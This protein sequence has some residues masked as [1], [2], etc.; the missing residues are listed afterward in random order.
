MKKNK[1]SINSIIFLL[2]LSFSLLQAS[3]SLLDSPYIYQSVN[4]ITGEYCEADTDYVN[5]ADP[6]I[7]IRRCYSN[8]GGWSFNLPLDQHLRQPANET[9]SFSYEYDGKGQLK[10]VFKNNSTTPSINVGYPPSPVG[11]MT[12]KI[13]N[14]HFSYE[15]EPSNNRLGIPPFLIKRI[16]H[17][18]TEISRYSYRQ[19]PFLRLQLLV[20]KDDSNGYFSINEYYDKKH[21][22]VGDRQVIIED[23][24]RDFRIGRIKLQKARFGKDETPVVTARYFYHHHCTEVLDAL[25]RKTYYYYDSGHLTAIEDYLDESLYRTERLFWKKENGEGDWMLTAKAWQDA[26]GKVIKCQ[27]FTYDANGNQTSETLYGMLS[28]KNTPL[29]L[30]NSEGLVENHGVESYSK[31]CTYSETPPFLLLSEREDNGKVV[32]YSYDPK[33]FQKTGEFIGT[34]TTILKRH[35]FEYDTEKRLIAFFVDDGSSFDLHDMQGVTERQATIFTYSSEESG[36]ALPIVKEEK[37]FD[38]QSGS[39]ITAR[40]TICNYNQQ[41]Y[42][43]AKQVFNRDNSLLSSASLSYDLF[44][45]LIKEIDEK[46]TG[47]EKTFN[48]NGDLLSETLIDNGVISKQTNYTY[49]AAGRLVTIN[50]IDGNGKTDSQTFQYNYAGEKISSTDHF[51]NTSTYVYDDLSRLIATKL[52]PVPDSQDQLH[53]PV[54]CNAYDILN[55]ITESID[56][57]G[58]KIS[59]WYTAYGKPIEKVYPDGTTESFIYFPDGSLKMAKNKKGMT[60]IYE[61]DVLGRETAMKILDAACTSRF[62]LTSSYSAFHLIK[63]TKDEI[64]ST[65]YTYDQAGRITAKEQHFPEGRQRIDYLYDSAGRIDSQIESWGH[66]NNETLISKHYYNSDG[67]LL[68]TA[69]SDLQGTLLSEIPAEFNKPSTEDTIESAVLNGRGQIVKQITSTD[70]QGQT[71]TA[72]YD[73][74]D[75]M[76]T[77]IRQNSQGQV[78]KHLEMRYD[79]AGNKIKETIFDKQSSKTKV[80]Q[81]RY[82]NCNRLI[83]AI[84]SAN[85]PYAKTTH[86]LYNASGLLE[87]VIKPDGITLFHHYSAIGQ[88][89]DYYASDSSFNYRFI[90]DNQGHL[91]TVEDLIT[92]TFTNRIYNTFGQIVY[93]ELGNGLKFSNTYDAIGRRTRLILPDNSSIACHFDPL[94]MRTIERFSGSG[95]LKYTH[96]Y[97]QYN[98]NGQVL[99]AAMIGAAGPLSLDYNGGRCIS[100]TASQW[101]EEIPDDGQDL[102]GNI[103]ALEGNDNHGTWRSSFSYNDCHEL[104]KEN[105]HINQ[106]YTYDSNGNRLARNH[107]AYD[108]N[109]FDQLLSQ[110]E[111]NNGDDAIVTYAYDSHGNLNE[112]RS[113]QN[114]TTYRYDALD[115]LISIE[116]EKTLFVQY[117]YDAFYRRLTKA[118]SVWNENSSSWTLRNSLRYLYDGDKEIG[119]VDSQG[120]ILELRVL[121]VSLMGENLHTEIGAAIAH[122]IH[123]HPFAPVHDHRGNVCCLIDSETGCAVEC[124]RYSAFGTFAIYSKD[125]SLLDTSLVNNPWL[126]SSKRYDEESGLI[127]YGKRYYDPATAKWISRDPLEAF[128]GANPY[129]FLHNNPLTHVDLYGLFSISNAWEG[130]KKLASSFAHALNTFKQNTSYTH[131][132]QGEWDRIAEQVFDKGYLQFA[133]YY[134]HSIDSGR[135]SYGEEIHDKVRITLINGILNA[136]YDFDTLLKRFSDTHGNTPIHY[137]FRPTEGWTKDLLSSTL[138]KFG[139]TSSYAKLLA[140]TWKKMIHEMGG[141]GQGGKIIHYAHSIGATDTY[142]AKNLLTEE[143]RR[144][145]HVISLGSPTMIPHGSGFGS[146]T[147]YVSKR[148]GVCLLDPIGYALGYF[149][150]N[151]KIEWVGSL[152]GIPL[153]DHTL[154]CGSYNE[155]ITELGMEFIEKY[156]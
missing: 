149:Y 101:S 54:I 93:E 75:R 88:L 73:V 30:I 31:R 38:I 67:S 63:T 126:F 121:G 58:N 52:P 1:I 104:V 18:E 42:L 139:Y 35:A 48:A 132:M 81:W 140:K 111:S 94:Y 108:Y 5:P 145:I 37:Y 53:S 69:V 125:G 74:L 3:E 133:G 109:S 55:N 89:T 124:F 44:G 25:D 82:D 137:V 28:G 32:T 27:T 19:H 22:D 49:D 95:K 128:D 40:R 148:D 43:E 6:Q 98:L 131:Q 134:S 155:V 135:T 17:Q 8:S 34:E 24:V 154:N 138:S 7:N 56:A 14:H 21:N 107:A 91:V 116:I 127:F 80:N 65:H 41:G 71:T 39:Y 83:T 92:H 59:T 72:I 79:L 47:F 62:S 122:E 113:A 90:Y 77:L 9:S 57:N 142:V 50:S 68:K 36:P 156:R 13:N 100:I 110:K 29:P 45:R 60:T 146:A 114:H 129:L 46:G 64:L 141:V 85:T 87:Q 96:T 150:E 106:N 136:R 20:R 23:P 15:F 147:N 102:F 117:S 103:L 78:I 115:R 4:V 70:C 86:Y 118:I 119:T 152:W 26:Q 12:L 2:T 130:T 153:I 51:G 143:E 105:S 151:S 10:A 97:S 33:T 61:R 112:K 66:H 144:M 76:E 123:G 84:E 120:N 16:C 99:Q 11:G